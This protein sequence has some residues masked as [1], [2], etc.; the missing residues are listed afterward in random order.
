MREVIGLVCDLHLA[1][2]VLAGNSRAIRLADA[3]A[4]VATSARRHL[5]TSRC[6]LDTS[7]YL[8]SQIETVT[9]SIFGDASFADASH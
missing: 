6:H 2:A 3:L 5:D 9:E 4:T 7:R 8:T 1:A